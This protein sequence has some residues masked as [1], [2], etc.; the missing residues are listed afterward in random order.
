MET[1]TTSCD[2]WCIVPKM[3]TLKN[4]WLLLPMLSLASCCASCSARATTKLR[5]GCD[6]SDFMTKSHQ[7]PNNKIMGVLPSIGFQTSLSLNM[8]MSDWCN[9]G[10]S[11]KNAIELH[12]PVSGSFSQFLSSTMTIF[13]DC[14]FSV[15]GSFLVML[16][17]HPWSIHNSAKNKIVSHEFIM[18]PELPIFSKLFIYKSIKHVPLCACYVIHQQIHWVVCK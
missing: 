3:F 13:F 11:S 4:Q 14:F 10:S 9:E 5:S 15:T 16:E 6:K 1:C 7:H 18:R 2:N 8:S 12:P 17:I